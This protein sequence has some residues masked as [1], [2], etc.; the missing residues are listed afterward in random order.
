MKNL[1]IVRHSKAVEY[2]QDHSDY[3]RCLAE[4]GIQKATQI[5]AE[6]TRDLHQV[7]RMISSPACRA[8][9]TAQIFAQALHF[10]EANIIKEE[11]LYHFGG[12]S[13]ALNI[14]SL[15]PDDVETLMLF[16]HNPTFS[17]L[18]WEL[19]TA[20]RNSMPTSAVVGISFQIQHWYE[21]ES[22][23]GKLLTFLTRKLLKS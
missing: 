6:L 2:A 23:N 8:F 9:E 17:A 1:Y 20:F 21:M 18:A 7:D 16:G 19:C 10:P 22:T 11:P 13:R 15:V 5:A 12:T 14:I 4:V 3:N